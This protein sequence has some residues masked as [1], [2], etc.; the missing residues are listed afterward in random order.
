V[1]AR[2]YRHIDIGPVVGMRPVVI[3]AGTK[4]AITIGRA[5]QGLNKTGYNFHFDAMVLLKTYG[6]ELI[7]SF[8]FKEFLNF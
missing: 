4:V 3:S 6:T 2:T 1:W 7:Y 5:S 8:L